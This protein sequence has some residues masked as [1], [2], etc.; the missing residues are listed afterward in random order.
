MLTT[1]RIHAQYKDKKKFIVDHTQP[2][3]LNNK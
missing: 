3:K 1:T 2:S